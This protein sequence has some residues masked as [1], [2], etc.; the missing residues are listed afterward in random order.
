MEKKEVVNNIS[1]FK[2]TLQE[3]IDI[4]LSIEEMGETI[5]IEGKDYIGVIEHLDK[6][7]SEIADTDFYSSTDVVLY[8]K[9]KEFIMKKRLAGKKLKVNGTSYIVNN[10]YFEEGMI[11]I[12][13]KEITAY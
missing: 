13:L 5:N 7:F 12:K 1:P 3:D 2:S 11:I 4:F 10:W 8:L 9:A 6:D